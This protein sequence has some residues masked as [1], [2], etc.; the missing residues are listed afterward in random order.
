MNPKQIK[1]TLQRLLGGDYRIMKISGAIV[2]DINPLGSNA[3][4]KTFR[5]GQSATEPEAQTLCDVYSVTV[6]ALKD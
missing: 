6:L 5:A 1:V 3:K 2:L 4:I